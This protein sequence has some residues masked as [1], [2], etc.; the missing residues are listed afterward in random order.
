MS[1]QLV[2]GKSRT[3]RNVIIFLGS[4]LL[5]LATPPALGQQAPGP[6]PPSPLSYLPME[7]MFWQAEQL[8]ATVDLELV[9]EGVRLA[10][11]IE[12]HQMA[13]ADRDL[14]LRDDLRVHLEIVGRPED[15]AST[16]PWSNRSV[17][18]LKA[19]R[20]TTRNAGSRS[21]S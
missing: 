6:P 21:T 3:G 15:S 19:R 2:A 18:K 10:D 16:Q 5:A 20:S 7:S 11:R 12:L 13:L 8:V 9:E 17:A 4:V 1:A 14:T